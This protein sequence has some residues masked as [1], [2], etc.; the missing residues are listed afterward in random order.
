MA[1]GFV[2]MRMT[3]EPP[4]ETTAYYEPTREYCPLWNDATLATNWPAGI[5]PILSLRD[6]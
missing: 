3:V 4:Y 2:V 5:Q 6:A 1:H